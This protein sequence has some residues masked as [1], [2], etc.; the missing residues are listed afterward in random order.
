VTYGVDDG[1]IFSAVMEI[2]SHA[3]RFS[4]S[5]P[6]AP[7]E[8][9]L[10]AVVTHEA[11]H[12]LGLAHSGDMSAVM[13]AFYQPGAITL[14][15]DDAAGICAVYPPSPSGCSC[16]VIPAAETHWPL[17]VLGLLALARYG[18]RR[19]VSRG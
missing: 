9:S 2:N 19:A 8:I 16:G 13:Y 4:T 14:T 5:V 11:G 17:G 3:Q 12:F 18:R 10:E 6:P 15:D 1:R 7:G